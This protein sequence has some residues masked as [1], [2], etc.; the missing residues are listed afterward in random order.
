MLT[1][2][3]SNLTKWSRLQHVHIQ[4]AW[5]TLIVLTRVHV[6][7]LNLYTNSTSLIDAH[8]LCVM[9]FDFMS[10]RRW[11][12]FVCQYS[13]P[14]YIASVDSSIGRNCRKDVVV[15]HTFIALFIY[16]WGTDQIRIYVI[17]CNGLISQAMCVTCVRSVL[18]LPCLFVAKPYILYTIH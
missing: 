13:L 12:S 10:T 2:E 1:I 15:E 16:R 3:I 7:Y 9:C 11:S 18:N 6:K 5:H 14:K 17:A 4:F 8:P